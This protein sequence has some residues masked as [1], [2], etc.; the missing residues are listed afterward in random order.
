MNKIFFS[1]G[2]AA[3]AFAG[4]K[5]RTDIINYQPASETLHI[6]SAYKVTDIPAP[7]LRNLLIEDF[8][9]VK[10]PNCP[11]AQIRAEE[12]D[13]ANP[14]RIVITALHV[15]SLADPLPISKYD[16]RTADATHVMEMIGNPVGLPMGSL[17]R[18]IFPGKSNQFLNYTEWDSKVPDELNLPT[19]VNISFLKKTYNET[20]RELDVKILVTFTQAVPDSSYISVAL[21]ESGMI[22][23]QETPTGND[24][25]YVH[26]HTLR[27]MVA[28]Y[29]GLLLG[30][31]VPAGKTYIV[32]F[33]RKLANDWVADNCT[34]AA[35][36]HHRS[37]KSDLEVQQVVETEV[38]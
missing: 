28:P 13:T 3:L 1:L 5:E 8:T 36:V 17:N 38:K 2:L 30:S 21:K 9:G 10:C 33:T 25:F 6:D 26:R 15:T 11:K 35:F 4:C 7:Q 24:T 27:A 14:G 29:N 20:T 32:A 19:P 22:D 16:F 31:N 12:I 34:I 37:G 23:I 18:K